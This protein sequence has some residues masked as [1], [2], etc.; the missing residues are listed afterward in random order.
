LIFDMRAI[1][2]GLVAVMRQGMMRFG[3]ADLRIGPRALLLADHE[4]DHAR[5]I[6]LE[7]EHLQV[8]HQV[9]VILEDRRDA[10]RF[11]HLR[12][13]QIAL[14]LRLLNAPLDVADRIGV[15]VDLGLILRAQRL[16]ERRQLVVHG[17][18]NALVLAEPRLTRGAIGAAAVAEQA[19]SNTARGLNSIGN[20]CVLL[21]HD[22]V[23]V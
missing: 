11:V 2:L 8:E 22:S 18:E 3:H 14:L 23:C 10:L 7:R 4:G 21:R 12:Q 16:S 17:I 5:Q 6:R 13:I 20:G 19:F 9:E 15:L 1:E